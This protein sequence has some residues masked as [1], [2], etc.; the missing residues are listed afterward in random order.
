MKILIRD[1]LAVLPDGAKVCSVCV[2]NGV[3]TAV[4]EIAPD[5]KAN[6]TILGSGRMLIPG[7]INT[8]THVYMTIFRNCA[9]DLT[10]NDW[11]FGR[12]L[13]LEDKLT[14]EDCYWG[15][16]LGIMEM[17]STGTTTFND[18]YPMTNVSARAATDA[19][20]RAVLSRG[21]VGDKDNVEGGQK[22]LNEAFAEME[23][24]KD[25]ENITFSLAPHAPYS[26]DE[27]YQAQVAG[28]AK[29]L[30]VRIHTHI[31][32]SLSENETIRAGY[33]CTPTE[34]MDKTGLLTDKTIAAHCVHLA[35]SDIA[36]LA[37]R[38][39]HVV[40][41]PVSNLK[42]ANGVAPVP[43]LLRAGI[44]VAVGTDGASSNNAL[45]MFRELSLLTILHKGVSGDPQAITAREGFDMATKNGAK[46]LGLSNLGE[47]K[48]GM[49]AD[50]SILD[51]DRPNMQPL[52]DPIAALAY[53]ANGSEVETVM[54]G[55]RI[56]MENGLF[57]TID[58]ERALF[59]VHKIC[60]RIG[61]R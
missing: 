4:G 7:L 27:S 18:M 13:P 15:T 39:V 25:I 55:G 10:F 33:S 57:T 6:K 41:N 11:L 1:I 37:K 19:G 28:E 2:D 31:S 34:L 3:I 60:E 38:G 43:K 24:W 9:D 30:G 36:L 58:K 17:L 51:L 32:E 49:K 54:V 23:K 50:L 20:M 40:T 44:N 16:L 21:L 14:S 46:A 35:D 22:R 12:I 5:F 56:V 45:N 29:R 48:T 53:S 52:N 8:H 59:E 26:C 61:T 42:L 47:I